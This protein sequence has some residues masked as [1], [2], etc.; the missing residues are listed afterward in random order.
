MFAPVV[1]GELL[2]DAELAKE[3]SKELSK[4]EAEA[5]EEIFGE[6]EFEGGAGPLAAAS[7]LGTDFFFFFFFF[8]ITIKQATEKPDGQ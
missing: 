1:A 2:E 4:E 3:L 5:V 6:A 7:P 8:L